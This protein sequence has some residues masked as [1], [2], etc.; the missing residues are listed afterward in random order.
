MKVQ[1]QACLNILEISEEASANAL[2][3]GLL[4]VMM[5]NKY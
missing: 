5:S 4:F 2:K 1:A 3:C